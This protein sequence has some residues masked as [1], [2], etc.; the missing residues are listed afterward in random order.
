MSIRDR[1]I[2]L[3]IV[4]LLIYTGWHLFLF[5]CS[6]YIHVVMFIDAKTHKFVSK[7]I[8]FNTFMGLATIQLLHG[9]A[10]FAVFFLYGILLRIIY[11][12]PIVWDVCFFSGFLILSISVGEFAIS[13]WTSILA[14]VF[15]WI[16]SGTVLLVLGNLI[17]KKIKENFF[18]RAL[19]LH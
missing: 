4:C 3:L 14:K 6:N 17:G 10:L 13:D 18:I 7:I 5:L 9:Y 19:S 15:V 1:V 8:K 2:R 12:K 11:D 16:I